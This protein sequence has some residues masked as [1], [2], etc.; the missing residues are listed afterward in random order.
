MDDASNDAATDD[1]YA[2]TQNTNVSILNNK[3]HTT[4]YT[5]CRFASGELPSVGSGQIASSGLDGMD[6][7]EGKEEVTKTW[8]CYIQN[9]WRLS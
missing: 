1:E 3:C 4:V 5:S 8:R 7:N 6:C 2:T 9:V